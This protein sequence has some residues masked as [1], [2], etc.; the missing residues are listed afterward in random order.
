MNDGEDLGESDM[1][2]MKFKE[3]SHQSH[4]PNVDSVIR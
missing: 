3:K 4:P 1:F 2:Q